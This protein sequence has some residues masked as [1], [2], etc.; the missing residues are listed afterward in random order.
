MVVSSCLDHQFHSLRPTSVER[1]RIASGIVVLVGERQNGCEGVDLELSLEDVGV[2][3]VLS[4]S[5]H[6][7]ARLQEDESSG[8]LC[9]VVCVG[10]RMACLVKVES[11]GV[12][13]NQDGFHL[14]IQNAT[15]QCAQLRILTGKS[16]IRN[17][18]ARWKT[19]QTIT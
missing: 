17:D 19:R 1:S 7:K 11:V 12:R 9:A 5:L 15:N 13:V 2:H 4:R 16:Q 14:T 18:L 6:V 8:A 3:G 10:I